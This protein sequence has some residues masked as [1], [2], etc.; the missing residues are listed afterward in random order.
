MLTSI[1]IITILAVAYTYFILTTRL[2][3]D[4]VQYLDDNHDISTHLFTFETEEELQTYLTN[5]V[6]NDLNRSM[7][8]RSVN[9]SFS[10]SEPEYISIGGLIEYFQLDI[11]NMED[12][13][14]EID[15]HIESQSLVVRTINININGHGNINTS[16]VYPADWFKSLFD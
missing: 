13:L 9:V 5:I 12:L 6:T 7:F 4:F 11:N 2:A 3:H 16:N 10:D 1:G 14:P 8:L 15:Q